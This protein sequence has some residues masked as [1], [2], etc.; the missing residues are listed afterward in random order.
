MG[1]ITYF[2]GMGIKCVDTAMVMANVPT[3]TLT[4]IFASGKGSA[5]YPIFWNTGSK[6]RTRIT[7]NGKQCLPRSGISGLDL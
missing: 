5:V 7:M 3:S 1:V 6:E 2:I 4:T